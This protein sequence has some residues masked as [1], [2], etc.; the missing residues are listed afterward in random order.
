MPQPDCVYCSDRYLYEYIYNPIAKHICF[1][2]PNIITI[3]GGL[4]TVP[5]YDNLKNNGSI[6]TLI[7]LGLLKTIFDC[8]DGSVAR[9]CKLGSDLG[10]LLDIGMDTVT[11][12]ILLYFVIYKLYINMNK[13]DYN[14]YLIIA[15]GLTMVYFINQVIEEIKGFRN[16]ETMFKT[17]F[18]K[19]F[20]DNL[21]VIVPFFYLIL[22][23]II[24]NFGN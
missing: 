8:L 3:I 21:T 14:R 13:Y 17:A 18:D 2:H 22:K 16:K 4:L 24:N 23:L 12:N 7:L 10:A 15:C 6:Y 19:F 5:M 11:L 9:K 1:I 20:H